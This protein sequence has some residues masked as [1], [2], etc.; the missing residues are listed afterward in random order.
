MFV[1]NVKP[2]SNPNGIRYILQSISMILASQNVQIAE[3]KDFVREKMP[4]E[5]PE[6]FSGFLSFSPFFSLFWKSDFEVNKKIPIGI[7]EQGSRSEPLP[8]LFRGDIC[9]FSSQ[10]SLLF[11]YFQKIF[12]KKIC[13]ERKR[14]NGIFSLSPP[15][16]NIYL[17]EIWC[18]RR[19]HY[20]RLHRENQT[21][22]G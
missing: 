1:Q 10:V 14:K 21:Y 5:K 15:Q 16:N 22:L 13:L 20:F 4:T 2:N 9:D 11:R 7:F 12:V 19:H 8:C 3:E 17:R 6:I 18:H